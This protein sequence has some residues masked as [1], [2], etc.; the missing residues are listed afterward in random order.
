MRSLTNKD[1]EKWNDVLS[2]MGIK[3]VISDNT[4][5]FF[6]IET[7]DNYLN[8]QI[9]QIQSYSNGG[10]ENKQIPI[11]SLNYQFSFSV[12]KKSLKRFDILL[13]NFLSEGLNYNITSDNY[14][15]KKEQ[16]V[17]QKI[18]YFNIF[19]TESEHKLYKVEYL[20]RIYDFKNINLIDLIYITTCV[21]D[22]VEIIQKYFEYDEDG[23]EICKLKYPIGS[24]V[25]LIIDKSKDYIIQSVRFTRY[26]I[27]DVYYIICE[28]K[29]DIKSEVLLF[30]EPIEVIESNICT[31]RDDRI[32]NI[33]N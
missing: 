2:K 13:G 17:K 24:I 16:I 5:V 9:N 7:T 10:Y 8:R 3:G 27:P 18:E 14:R 21:E 19:L 11:P 15:G 22:A 25:S 32:N 20:R 4:L 23:N 31:N 30:S 12:S 29:N 28:I 1:L 26:T 6:K 33:L